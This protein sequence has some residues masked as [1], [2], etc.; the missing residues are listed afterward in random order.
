MLICNF[1]FSNYIHYKISNNILQCVHKATMCYSDIYLLF[2]QR[3]YHTSIPYIIFSALSIVGAVLAFKFLPE[4]KGVPLP[5]NVLTIEK[6]CHPVE[7][8]KSAERTDSHVANYGENGH[9]VIP[10]V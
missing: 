3:N 4:T 10:Q 8:T 9:A 7:C 6:E 5:D 1:L 2:F